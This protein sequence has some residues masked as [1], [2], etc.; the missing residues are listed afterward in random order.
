MTESVVVTLIVL[1]FFTALSILSSKAEKE[2][3]RRAREKQEAV[4]KK[5]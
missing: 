4:R 3:T 1:L 5:R 2:V